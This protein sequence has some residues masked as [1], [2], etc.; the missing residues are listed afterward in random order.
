MPFRVLALESSCDEFAGAVIEDGIEVLASVVASQAGIHARYGGVVP[1]IA[2]REHLRNLAPVMQA[3]LESAG[4]DWDDLDAI[5][6]TQGPGLG[7]SLLVG[8]NAAKTAAWAR[9]L[10]LIPVHHI[11]GHL[12][13]NWLR[14]ARDDW[15]DSPPP[16]PLVALVVSGGHTELFW[17]QDHD[18]V[19]RVG[20][21]LDDAAGEAFDKVGRL[22][23][24]PFP[25]GPEIERAAN[26]ASR[27]EIE[28]LDPLP[29]AWLPGTYDF[30]F[31]GLKTAVLN[32]VRKLERAGDPLNVPAM[33]ARF[34]ES[35][36]DVLSR[37]TVR[38]AED[39]GASCV[40]VAGGVA[41]NAALRDALRERCAEIGLPLRVP[42]PRL[43]TDNAAMIGAAA[44]YRRS[45]AGLDIDVFSTSGPEVFSPGL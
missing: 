27:P 40:I 1:E 13:A 44:C 36:T 4:L 22:L 32:R 19:E 26:Q 11:A 23:G 14:P 35:V 5:A 16:F 24:L 38:A 43:C 30:S 8:V 3:T 45:E 39:L 20:Q 18:R 7:G 12:Y 29:R 21:T 2:G 31:S 15:D 9:G 41:A 42:P 17:M 25:G 34:Q 28:A 10:P 37:K 33:A 6:V